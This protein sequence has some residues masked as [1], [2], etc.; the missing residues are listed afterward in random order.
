M[1]QAESAFRSGLLE[2]AE[3][4]LLHSIEQW[5][6]LTEHFPQQD[7]DWQALSE[8]YESLAETQQQLGNYEQARASMLESDISRLYLDAQP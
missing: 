8:A 6:W 4:A 5:K 7:I 3:Q 2:Q 1:Q